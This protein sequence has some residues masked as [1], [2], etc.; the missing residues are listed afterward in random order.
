MSNF[1]E[2]LKWRGLVFDATEGLVRAQLEVCPR[3]RFN[4]CLGVAGAE[5]ERSC[6]GRQRHAQVRTSQGGVSV[7]R[8][9]VK[10][11][12]THR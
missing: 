5:R 6:S 12:S 11:M 7:L 3:G 9:L 2:E 4:G 8:E 10:C 1:L